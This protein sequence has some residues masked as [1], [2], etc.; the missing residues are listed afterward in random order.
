M[1]RDRC[2]F[3]PPQETTDVIDYRIE[4]RGR[5]RE[6]HPRS[7]KRMEVHTLSRAVMFQGN[8]SLRPSNCRNKN[9]AV[10]RQHS[11]LR[12][13][14]FPALRSSKVRIRRALQHWAGLDH[15]P[16]DAFICFDFIRHDVWCEW[17]CAPISYAPFYRKTIC[18][19]SLSFAHTAGK[20]RRQPHDC[21]PTGS[22]RAK[23][24]RRD[25]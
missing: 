23:C 6:E 4:V 12:R 9:I 13:K 21:T 20:Q 5:R 1:Y 14:S 16:F 22:R 17:A 7:Y 8:Q 24:S 11:G 25:D 3:N 15:E 19:N 2:H 18:I 10:L